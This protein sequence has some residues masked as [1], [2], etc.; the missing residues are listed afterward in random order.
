MLKMGYSC[1]S[2]GAEILISS[3]RDK[4]ELCRFVIREERTRL[5]WAEVSCLVSYPVSY[6]YVW[7]NYLSTPIGTFGLGKH[8]GDF[9]REGVLLG[10]VVEAQEYLIHF[11]NLLS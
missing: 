7:H 5:M 9:N 10:W 6:Q 1:P 4:W 11:S 2:L 8:T 3:S